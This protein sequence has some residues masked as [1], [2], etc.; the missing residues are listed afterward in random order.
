MSDYLGNLIARTVSAG[1][2]V[3]PRLPSLFEPVP[4]AGEAKSA[5]EFEQENFVERPPER[6]PVIPFSETFAPIPLPIP[7]SRQSVLREP[8]QTVTEISPAKKILKAGK[9]SEPVAQP[10]LIHEA[11]Q[12]GIFSGAAPIVTGDDP[13]NPIRSK[14]DATKSPLRGAIMSVSHEATARQG[15]GPSQ[16]PVALGPVIATIRSSPP[17]APLPLVPTKAPPTINVTI[18]RVEVRAVMPH[19]TVPKPA[20]RSAPKLS[21]EEYLKQRNGSRS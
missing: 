12:P 14:S 8:E 19:V 15:P 1:A 4:A 11:V 17:I 10:A 21:L 6:P 9:E 2:A 20:S 16:P 7:T 13:L 3:R 18:G 5:P